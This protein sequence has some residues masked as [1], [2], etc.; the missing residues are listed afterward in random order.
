MWGDLGP[1]VAKAQV[2][3]R[4]MCKESGLNLGDTDLIMDELSEWKLYNLHKTA[5][6]KDR[7]SQRPR[8]GIV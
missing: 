4:E 5:K 3:I 1:I 8:S 7:R 6:K 2:M